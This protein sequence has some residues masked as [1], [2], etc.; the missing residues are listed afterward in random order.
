[1][2]WVA[3]QWDQAAAVI[4]AP[5]GLMRGQSSKQL[6]RP[7]IFGA[8][9]LHQGIA[10]NIRAFTCEVLILCQRDSLLAKYP[11]IQFSLQYL[12]EKRSRISP[13]LLSPLL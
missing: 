12:V 2:R 6:L 13:P 7:M 9:L 4:K 3:L 1:M 8:L 10:V 5:L 11:L